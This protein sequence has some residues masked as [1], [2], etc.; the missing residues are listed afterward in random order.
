MGSRGQK[1]TDFVEDMPADKRACS[2]LEFKPSSSNSMPVENPVVPPPPVNSVNSMPEVIDGGMD[3]SSLSASGRSESD[4]DTYGSCDSDGE[5]VHQNIRGYRPAAIAENRKFQ[6]ILSCLGEEG[7]KSGAMVV[8]TELC[9]LLSFSPDGSLSSLIVEPLSPILVNLAKN[10]TNPEIMLLSIRAM[11]YLCDVHPRSSSF[12]VQ[13]DAVPALCQRLMA[14]EYLDVAEQCCEALQKISY[15]QP[16]ACLQSGAIMAVLSFIDFFSRSVQRVAVSTVVNICKRLP[17]ESLSSVTEAV[18]VLCNLLQYDD[19]QIVENVVTCLIKITERAQKSVDMLNELCE[20]GVIH[21]TTHLIGLS[22][23]IALSMPIYSGLVGV[24]V[25]LASGSIRAVRSLFDHDIIAMVKDIFSSFDLSHSIASSHVT[26]GFSGQPHIHEVLKL[27]DVLL[28]AQRGNQNIELNLEKQAFLNDHPD[29]FQKFKKEILPILMQVVNSGASVHVCHGSLHVI[30]KFVYFSEPEMLDELLRGTNISSF[31]AGVLTRKDRHIQILA[32]QIV[33]ILLQKLSDVFLN[34]FV[35]EGVSFAIDSLLIPDKRLQSV[36]PVNSGIQMPKGSSKTISPRSVVRCLCYAFHPSLASE[37][38]TCEINESSIPSLAE[39]IKKKYFATLLNDVKGTDVLCDLKAL[40][41]SLNNLN[42][43]SLNEQKFQIMCQIMEK[44]IGGESA[45]T[46]EFIE[47]GIVSSLVTYLSC[48]QSTEGSSQINHVEKRFEEFGSLFLPSEDKE[49]IPLSVIV[50]KLQIALSSVENC[51]VFLNHGQRLRHSYASFPNGMCKPYPCLTVQFIREEGETSLSDYSDS[52][53]TVDP[54]VSLNSIGWDL[55]PKVILHVNK[56]GEKHDADHLEIQESLE[57]NNEQYNPSKSFE[58]NRD[59]TS[60]LVFYLD[61]T[62]MDLG[63]SLYQNIILVNNEE[64]IDGSRNLWSQLHKI[65]YRRQRKQNYQ[66]DVIHSENKDRTCWHQPFFFSNI[67]SSAVINLDDPSVCDILVV[68]K[69]LE[70][71][72][73]SMF[74]LASHKKL[75]DFA[76]GRTDNLDTLR[77]VISSIPMKEFVN[78]KLNEKL[79]QQMRDS[80]AVSVGSF[81]CWCLWLMESCPFVFGFDVKSKYFRLAA[82]SQPLNQPQQPSSNSDSRRLVGRVPKKKFLV[83][84]DRI[85]DSATKMMDLHARQKGVVEIEYN[86]EIG[87]GLGPTLEFF[88]LVSHEFQLSALGMWRDDYITN[89]TDGDSRTLVSSCGLFPRP[90][91][92]CSK[93]EVEFSDVIKKFV[94]LGQFV[95]KALHDGRVFDIPFSK[96]FYKLILGQELT[97]YDIHLF[98]PELGRSLLEFLAIV[99]RHKYLK[100]INGE[101]FVVEDISCFRGTRIEDLCLDFT[102]PGYPN[103]FL[104]SASDSPK[105]VNL[106]N[107]EEYVNLVVEATIG[108]GIS[109]QIEAFKSGFNQVFLIKHLRIFTEEELEHLLCGER[110]QW[111]KNELLDNIKFDHGYTATSPTIINLLEIIQEFDQEQ[112]RHFLQFVTGAPRLPSGGLASLNP[113]LT[114]VCKNSGGCIDDGVLP[115]VMTCANYLKLPPYSTKEI[116]R[117]KLLYAIIEGQG[118]FHLS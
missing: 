11:T 46:F 22:C 73:R 19:H 29:L 104:S 88:T 95:A 91:S 64:E 107:L 20:F 23:K 96:A 4:T 5:P 21:Q 26:E 81:P 38:D 27:L 47:S 94:L 13:H 118:S 3:S 98:D 31:L 117:E 106:S 10:E 111:T 8:L 51:H 65:T 56:E 63:L 113:K 77:A 33:D 25:K 70:G 30:N 15:G 102:L 37:G 72:N 61:E 101:E 67:L 55:L 54:F 32:L 24:Y 90:M 41:A 85:L 89:P 71:I 6:R 75:H 87:T 35:K 59:S 68:L 100:S 45:S 86:Q 28:P 74:H 110:R 97:L 2:S 50:E 69:S 53:Q 57:N 114:I 76:R 66:T 84:R 17:S 39:L 14:I 36:I 82:F 49:Q 12:L 34:P 18:P 93:T 92:S 58:E 83:C 1:R 62:Q 115:S 78:V 7:D 9:E 79:E 40:A 109:K 60:G 99:E 44:L 105:L 112:Q 16:L 48:N 43:L 42:I 52:V 116:L 108:D 80:L 103:H